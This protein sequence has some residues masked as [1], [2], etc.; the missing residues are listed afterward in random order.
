MHGIVCWVMVYGYKLGVTRLDKTVRFYRLAG[1][2]LSFSELQFFQ[3]SYT[4]VFDFLYFIENF[5][6]VVDHLS[7][8]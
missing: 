8:D 6:P 3:I 4:I 7:V 2:L 1:P 5:A